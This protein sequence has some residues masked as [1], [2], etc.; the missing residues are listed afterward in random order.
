MLRSRVA[1]ATVDE[2]ETN[3]E[4]EHP[5]DSRYDTDFAGVFFLKTG[6]YQ[7]YKQSVGL[8]KGT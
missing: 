4:C 1:Q 7:R 3:V 6:Y 2:L 8:R 5:R